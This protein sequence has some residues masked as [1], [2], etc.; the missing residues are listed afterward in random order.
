MLIHVTA[1]IPQQPN[2]PLQIAGQFDVVGVVPEQAVAAGRHVLISFPVVRL[3]QSR[4][5]VEFDAKA[6]VAKL[7]PE[8]VP[9][10]VIDPFRHEQRSGVAAAY[11]S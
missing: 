3:T 8:P 7:A 11:H 10:R 6:P 1:E 2:A 5:V 9:I 4:A